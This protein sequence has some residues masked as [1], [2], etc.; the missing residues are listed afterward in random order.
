MN[1][2]LGRAE[3]LSWRRQECYVVLSSRP[4]PPFPTLCQHCPITLLEQVTHS[5]SWVC[6]PPLMS[7]TKFHTHTEPQAK[8]WCV[9][10]NFY[11]SR[12]QTRRQKVLDWMV[13]SITRVQSPLSNASIGEM[14]QTWLFCENSGAQW[15][16]RPDAV[17]PASVTDV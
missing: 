7:E 14:I 17:S 2:G 10:S 13:A 5:W 3:I 16:M 11:V 4:P 9:Y 12:Q 15:V 8:L 6:V 1:F